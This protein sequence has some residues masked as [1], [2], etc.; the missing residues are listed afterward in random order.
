M[1]PWS[2][3]DPS[4]QPLCDLYHGAACTPSDIRDHVPTLLLFSRLVDH[5][6]E[7]GTGSC[8]STTA[9]ARG[10]PQTLISYDVSP[11]AQAPDL[12]NAAVLAGVDIRFIRA[13]SLEA[14]IEPTDLLF[15][16][17]L[18]TGD[19]LFLELVH[20]AP[21]TRRYIIMHDTETFG[22]D[23]EIPGSKGLL[24]A[25][26]AYF[27]PKGRIWKFVNHWPNNNGLTI[28]KRVG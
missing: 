25:L 3:V 11:S 4:L 23:G 13:S 19:Q 5:V 21:K 15:I 2:K 16:D 9:L 7:L 1:E 17:T 18:H 28:F 20:H 14:D 6:T 10:L 26:M 8:R 22:V 12:E 27:R 24:Y